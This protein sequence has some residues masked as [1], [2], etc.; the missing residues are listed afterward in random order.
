MA[1]CAGAGQK[2]DFFVKKSSF[3]VI[4]NISFKRL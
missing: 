1:T 3:V 2:F 4:V